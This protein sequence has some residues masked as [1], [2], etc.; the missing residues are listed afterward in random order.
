[1]G[2][3]RKIFCPSFGIVVCALNK[4]YHDEAKKCK[5]HF[6]AWVGGVSWLVGGSTRSSINKKLAVFIFRFFKCTIDSLYLYSL[7]LKKIIL[8]CPNIYTEERNI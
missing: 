8:E 6:F 7:C 1:M 5:V 3:N 4:I 2:K